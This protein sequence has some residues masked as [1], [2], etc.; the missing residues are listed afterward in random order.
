MNIHTMR[1][2]FFLV[3]K[4]GDAHRFYSCIKMDENYRFYKGPRLK[5]I[6]L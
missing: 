2:L 4:K 1:F 6:L 3:L 5:N